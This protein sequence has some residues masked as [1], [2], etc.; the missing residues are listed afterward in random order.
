[1]LLSFFFFCPPAPLASKF[2]PLVLEHSSNF[3]QSF[4]RIPFHRVQK[5]QFVPLL[6]AR[7][8]FF[9]QAALPCWNFRRVR[10]TNVC[11]QIVNR[12][13]SI[14]ESPRSGLFCGG[15]ACW[16]PGSFCLRSL[17]LMRLGSPM[18]FAAGPFFPLCL[19]ALPIE[20]FKA[21]PAPVG[22][23]SGSLIT[24]LLFFVYDSFL[25]AR[26]F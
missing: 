14:V 9:F 25:I 7:S 15:S 1:L 20:V 11:V 12:C 18:R 24:L 21:P 17:R 23:E 3:G 10:R 8:S 2:F 26:D 22:V 4:A 13:V 5:S 19:I 6:P 16:I